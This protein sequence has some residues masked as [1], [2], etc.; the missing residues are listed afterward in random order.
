LV[1]SPSTAAVVSS[2]S[3]V[4]TSIAPVAASAPVANSSESPGRNGVTTTPVSKNTM[5]NSSA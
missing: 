2:T 1:L 3:T 5:R 4:V